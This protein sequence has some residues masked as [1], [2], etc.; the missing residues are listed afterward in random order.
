MP[1]SLY[2]L[3]VAEI[4]HALSECATTRLGEAVRQLAFLDVLNALETMTEQEW[5]DWLKEEA[6]LS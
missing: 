3:V 4:D 5:R 6:G 2:D 1:K